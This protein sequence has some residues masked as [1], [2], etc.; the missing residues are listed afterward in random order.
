MVVIGSHCLRLGDGALILGLL[1]WV[2]ELGAVLAARGGSGGDWLLL[3]WVGVTLVGMYLPL[4]LQR[5][6]SL[7]LG[8][9]L[10][11]LAGLGWWRVVRPRGGARRR[12]L[13]QGL[14]V[15]FCALT[16]VFLVL[17]TLLAALAGEPWF[18][19]SEGEWATLEWLRDEGQPDVVVLCAPQMGLFVPA[20]AGQP[21]V[22]GHPFETVDAERRKA[23]VEAF[24]A[25]DMGPAE[26][27]VFLQENRVGYVLVGPRELE[28]GDWRLEVGDWRLE[29]GE[30]EGKPVFEA[31]GV[32]VYEV[33]R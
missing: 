15:T 13:L 21:V 33:T 12:G 14:V 8:V 18:Y 23:Q 10:G 19:L 31:N 5:R 20:W 25:G 24:W 16:L 4:P 28:I 29:I 9:P 17:M 30:M 1:V 26:Q 11:L 3:G 2:E 32:R 22:Y 6:L 7:G 27:E